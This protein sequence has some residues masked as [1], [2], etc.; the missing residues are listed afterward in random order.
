MA[1][2][3]LAQHHADVAF[4]ADEL[5]QHLT[6]RKIPGDGRR[7]IVPCC[8]EVI[9]GLLWL[10]GS[11]KVR[12]SEA[13]PVTYQ[14]NLIYTRAEAV[15]PGGA[16]PSDSGAPPTPA[17]ASGSIEAEAAVDGATAPR[18]LALD[19]GSSGAALQGM[20][21]QAMLSQRTCGSPATKACALPHAGRRLHAAN[22][23]VTY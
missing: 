11:C 17:A 4:D 9:A 21:S 1:T 22:A 16:G 7:Y 3:N 19:S 18:G 15:S 8:V 20:D 14:Q 6:S 12:L 23:V 10:S 5:R 13:Q 2:L